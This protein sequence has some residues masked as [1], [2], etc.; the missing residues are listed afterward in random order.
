MS[1]CTPILATSLGICL[2]AATAAPVS[3]QS[4]QWTAMASSA[5][6]CGGQYECVPS[7]LLTEA[8]AK[9]CIGYPHPVRT[10]LERHVDATPA[11]DSC[12]TCEGTHQR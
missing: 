9:R 7:I 5:I 11:K 4:A 3:A 8:E 1:K 6:E 2:I 12:D 10:P